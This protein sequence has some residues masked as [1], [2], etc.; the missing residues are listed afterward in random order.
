MVEPFWM[1]LDDTN[2]RIPRDKILGVAQKF[3][4]KFGKQA[5]VCHVNPALGLSET[6]IDGIKIIL[7]RNVQ[8]NC[9]WM[10]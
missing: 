8:P 5:T 1:Y 10:G 2:S 4:A 3:F 9:F 6:D 7:S